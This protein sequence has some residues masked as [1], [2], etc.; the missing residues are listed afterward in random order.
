MGDET[1]NPKNAP[2]MIK[3]S[4]CSQHPPLASLPTACITREFL[5]ST[6]CLQLLVPQNDRDLH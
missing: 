1:H 6:G 4:K 2:L 5:G 3:L